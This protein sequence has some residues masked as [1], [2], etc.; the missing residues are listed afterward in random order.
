[1]ETEETPK[2]GKDEGHDDEVVV[3]TQFVVKLN[4]DELTDWTLAATLRL[5]VDTEKD[6]VDEVG[7]V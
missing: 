5:A 4:A 2:A 7:W 6:N 1:M 3:D